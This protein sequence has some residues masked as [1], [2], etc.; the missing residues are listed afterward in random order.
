MHG[1]VHAPSPLYPYYYLQ[2]FTDIDYSTQLSTMNAKQHEAVD[3]CYSLIDIH[4][5]H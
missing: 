1:V 5:I 2:T 4:I 3:I